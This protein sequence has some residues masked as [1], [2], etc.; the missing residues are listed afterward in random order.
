TGGGD[1]SPQ[2]P[3]VTITSNALTV[4]EGGSIALPISVSPAAQGDP[5]AVVI[6]GL[7]SYETLTDG[8]DHH[9]FSGD[10][11]TLT[12]AEVASGL[13]LT[14]NYMG[15]G[16]PVTTLSVT[17]AELMDHHV[18]TSAPQTITVTD[19]PA[20]SGSSTGN[21]LTLQV[22][23]DNLNGADPQFQ[24]L[25]DGHQV[26]GT[27]TVTA[28]HAAGQT[29]TVTINGNFDPLTAHQ[30]QVQFINDGWDGTSWWTN[31]TPPDGHDVN[32]Y[33]ESIS[34]N[35]MT[36][37][38]VQGTNGATNGIA[39]AANAH[40]AV[41]DVNGALSFNVPA[42]PPAGSGSS[43]GTGTTGSGGTGTSSGGTGTTTTG[44][45][46]TLQVSGDNLNGTDAQFQVLVDGHQVGGT[47]TVTADHAAGQ[48]QTVTINGNF[49]PL[50][51]HQVQVQFIDRKS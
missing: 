51:A 14:S 30:V 22:S 9:V 41:M 40:E 48:T 19:P 3:S 50:T 16:H 4:T 28:D 23:G 24:V 34:L 1:P 33:V 49:D 20:A 15:P 47:F 36:M 43:G 25:V 12:G 17:A 35:G 44:N 46:L 13:T 8:F 32:L 7:A 37:T 10:T 6:K 29:Q 5:L 38:G 26:G 11:V 31:G 39:P 45:P 27:F 18:L 2:A 42:D 21:P